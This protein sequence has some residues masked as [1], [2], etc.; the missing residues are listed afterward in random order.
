MK[1]KKGLLGTIILSLLVFVVILSSFVYFQL[2]TDGLRFATGSV[3]INIDYNESD[4]APG[5]GIQTETNKTNLTIIEPEGQIIIT[6]E[7]LSFTH[8][9]S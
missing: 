1:S 9:N 3:V 2:R 8:N 6:E 5:Q 4:E 7:N